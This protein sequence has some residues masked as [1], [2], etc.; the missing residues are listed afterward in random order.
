MIILAMSTKIIK[1]VATMTDDDVCTN[2]EAMTNMTNM[3]TMTDDDVCTNMEAR[4]A[5]VELLVAILQ[6]GLENLLKIFTNVET[7]NIYHS[8]QKGQK[9]FFSCFYIFHLPHLS[10]TQRLL[11]SIT[12]LPLS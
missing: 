5:P 3:E 9:L 4:P 8:K 11:S 12:S 2:M 6:P 10:I 1:T 7:K